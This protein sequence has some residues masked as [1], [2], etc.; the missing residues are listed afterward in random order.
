MLGCF[1]G[2]LGPVEFEAKRLRAITSDRQLLPKERGV[3]TPDYSDS[4]NWFD[5]KHCY[6]G[7][8]GALAPGLGPRV[9]GARL[10]KPAGMGQR[11]GCIQN[12][13]ASNLSFKDFL[14]LF[15]RAILGS[16]QP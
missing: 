11:L 4:E 2:S 1:T 9:S 15:F 12:R 7:G 16:Q 6:Q 5:L 10:G 8:A 3:P 13:Q 14:K